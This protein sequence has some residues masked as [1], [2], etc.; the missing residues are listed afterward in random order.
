[1]FIIE[2]F[3][4][5]GD[6]M[7]N[8][9]VVN[10]VGSVGH[11]IYTNSVNGYTV[12]EIETED[13]LVTATGTMPYLAEGEE[14]SMTGVWTNHPTF[15]RQFKVEAYEKKMPTGTTAIFKYLASGIIKGL[16]PALA[17]RIVDKFGAQSL[18][19]CE[20][21]CEWLSDIKGISPEKAK[22]I[23]ESFNS[24]FGLRNIIIFC[25]EFFGVSTAMRIYKRWGAA[26]IEVV[27]ANPYVISDEIFGVG[28]QKVDEFAKKKGIKD[29]DPLRLCAALKYIIRHNAGQNGHVYVPEK[30]LIEVCATLTGAQSSKVR[31][32]LEK[33]V[34]DGSVV[35][36]RLLE[37]NA[38][39]LKKYYDAEQ[40]TARKLF[41]LLT[42]GVIHKNI[43][44]IDSVIES[45][46]KAD[47]IEYALLQKQAIKTAVESGVMVL[48][49][50][51]GTGKTTI[52][53][54]ILRILD[55][56][57]ISVVLAAPTGRSAKRLEIATG[58]EAKTIHR[59]LEAELG[60]DK[61]DSFGKNAA[62]PLEADYI[63]IDEAS[64]VDI[65]LMEALLKA[66]KPGA[67]LLIIGD[68]DQ[69]P[70]VGAGNVLQDIINSGE[71]PTVSLKEIYRQASESQIIVNAHLINSGEYPVLDKKDSDFFYI[72][73]ESPEDVNRTVTE[74]IQY[75]L[76]KAYGEM[77]DEA[78]VIIPSHKGKNGTD[79]LNRIMQNA[80]N[81]PRSAKL[82]VKV[83]DK[84]FREGDKV[85]QMR[86]DYNIIWKDED[87]EEGSGVYNGDI[88]YI[89]TIDMGSETVYVVYDNRCAEYDFPMLDDLDHAYAITVHKSQGSEYP[90]VVLPLYDF[91]KK[92][93][94]R[95][96]LYTAITRAQNLL[97][98]VGRKEVVYRMVD[99]YKET[100]RFTDLAD[101]IAEYMI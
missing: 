6:I 59:L 90:I 77:G 89:K 21:H 99:N 34:C 55:K 64:M 48:T 73:R 12:A 8:D 61:G 22:Q 3:V 51:P 81:P 96:L 52:V 49:G 97:I 69:L 70:A 31:D 65:L 86:N 79:E 75:R 23:G 25:G 91:P 100:V 101:T 37:N 45:I 85:M 7:E 40:Y 72:S 28:F 82:E 80:I 14:I 93:Q 74:L 11:I 63:I 43:I 19:V 41:E 33:C 53:K 95:N 32:A 78:Q 26:S 38:I 84:V 57:G 92:L 36:K 1:M 66:I 46:E 83:G 67:Q 87:G 98:I 20:C 54:A 42:A 56:S 13:E 35:R 29:D 4:K 5:R 76:P 50:G 24:Q 10:I 18:E 88:G 2:T 44:D 47:G 15:G 68:K 60:T 39:Y 58:C 27:S 30:K 94:V 62:S 9:N 71:I 17:K 16:G